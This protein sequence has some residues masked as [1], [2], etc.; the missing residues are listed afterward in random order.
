MKRGAV[1]VPQGLQQQQRHCLGCH[2]LC[3]DRGTIYCPPTEPQ[4]LTS[5]LAPP[6]LPGGMGE[7]EE[8]CTVAVG[9]R[10]VLMLCLGSKRQKFLRKKEVKLSY[11]ILVSLCALPDIWSCLAASYLQHEQKYLH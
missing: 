6:A 8:N 10:L 1:G 5:S 3:W 9:A 4:L 7:P 2:L 11:P